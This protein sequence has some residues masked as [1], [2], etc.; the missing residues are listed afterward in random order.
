[1]RLQIMTSLLTSRKCCDEHDIVH[2]AVKCCHLV[3]DY[4]HEGVPESTENGVDALGLGNNRAQQ[5]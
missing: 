1:M 5:W 4:P 3:H 2:D